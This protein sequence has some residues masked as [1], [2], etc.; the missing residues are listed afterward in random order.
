MTEA[1]NLDDVETGEQM[2]GLPGVRKG[3]MSLRKDRPEL[4]VSSVGFSP[5]G[6]LGINP[7]PGTPV[8]RSLCG[9]LG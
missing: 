4:R 2:A 5:T 6:Q 9:Q 8:W 1:G 7:G 3:D